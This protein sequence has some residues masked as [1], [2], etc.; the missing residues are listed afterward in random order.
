MIRWV[1]LAVVAASSA[2]V[3][4]PMPHNP[5]RVSTWAWEPGM[6]VDGT[7]RIWVVGNHCPF[8]DQHGSCLPVDHIA[9]PAD[10]TP[11]WRSDDDGRT[12]RWIA[13]PLAGLAGIDRPG[14][15]DSD[16]A[17]APL[18]RPGHGPIVAVSSLFGLSTTLALS[19]DDGATWKVAQLSGVPL[20][21][22]PWVVAD[23]QCDLYVGYH[24]ITGATNV[25]SEPIVNRYDACS[26]MDHGVAGQLVATPATIAVVPPL[27]ASN[28]DVAKT[29]VAGGRVY[30]AHLA[31]DSAIATPSCNGPGDHQTMHVG[32]STDRA[33][34]FT[35]VA[36][37]D[38][39]LHGDMNDGT[40]PVTAAADA[41]GHVV[42]AACDA[43]HVWLWR[44]SDFGATWQAVHTPVDAGTGWTL[45]SVASIAVRGA[46]VA[47]AWNGSPPVAAPA[48]QP[49]SLVV[50]RSDNGGAT[51]ATTVVPPVLATTA[52][53]GALADGLYDDFGLVITA[54][55][56]IL[57][58]YTQSCDGHAPTDAA[59]PGPKPGDV[60]TFDVVRWARLAPPLTGAPGAT[61]GPPPA[62]VAGAGRRPLP[63]TGDTNDAALLGVL[64]L[65]VAVASRAWAGASRR[66]GPSPN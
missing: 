25:A 54:Q 65:L 55:G 64:L 20:Q 30:V 66:S 48:G 9:Q 27:P 50:A 10:T 4:G 53:G 11:V 42:V 17:V 44:S 33:A 40:W 12:F 8:A 1:V 38:L 51:F 49:W 16:L 62:T 35:D 39:G 59:C 41:A 19:D 46:T 43:H 60:G 22:R 45:A 47:V 57:A 26:L 14:G 34:T 63:P 2:V 28:Q 7:G 23:G 29:V 3:S 36:L 13:D 5:T 37:P 18:A 21:D 56:A 31:C 6:A 24:L 61:A 15:N 32:V 58:T 52:T